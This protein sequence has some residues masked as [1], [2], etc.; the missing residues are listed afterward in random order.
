M[1]AVRALVTWFVTFV[2]L[3]LVLAVIGAALGGFGLSMYE[4]VLV[5]AV[6]IAL[7]Y[8]LLR[9]WDRRSRGAGTSTV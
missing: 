2:L 6:S 9:R 8:F 7:T 1:T 4:L 3:L 5:L